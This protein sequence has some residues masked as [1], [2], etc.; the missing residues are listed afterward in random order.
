MAQG[1]EWGLRDYGQDTQ[2]TW[3]GDTV[4][5][6]EW[7]KGITRK[8]SGGTRTSRVTNNSDDRIHFVCKSS[9]C[10]K[11]GAWRGQLGLEPTP[12]LYIKHICGILDEAKRVLKKSGSLYLNLGDTYCGS[13]G[14]ESKNSSIEKQPRKSPQ[15]RVNYGRWLQPKQL[16]LMPSRVAIAL[17]EGGWILRNDIIYKKLNPMPNSVKDRLTNTYEHVFHFVKSRRYF[18]DLDAIRE[19][20]KDSNPNDLKRAIGKHPGY[21]GK[22]ASGYNSLY[23]R[24]L[25]GQGMKGQPVGDPIQGKNPGD[26]IRDYHSKAL[27]YLEN[28]PHRERQ[29]GV[30]EA[31]HL[32]GKNP[33]DFWEI[34]TQPFRGAHFAVYPEKLCEMP[35][36]ASCPEQVCKRCGEPRVKILRQRIGFGRNP[37]K[38]K[39]D[40]RISTAGRLAQ[41]RQAY[42]NLGYESPPAPAIIGYT[43]CACKAGFEPGIVLDIFSGSGTTCV[44]AKKLGR[45]WI[46]IDINPGYC[47]MARKRLAKV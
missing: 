6:H 40:T 4:C 46:G 7:G 18:Y 28:N 43:D 17:Q 39:Y 38:T 42:R 8:Q 27:P 21:S 24:N 34:K 36:K 22:Y 16:L 45:R 3:D 9:F 2:T 35:I 29:F 37:S 30:Q 12:H 33:G 41:R 11:C 1:E 19:P 31:G 13:W 10:S 25:P 20:W 15:A 47:R 23:R 44:V 26:V 5:T 32:L 14:S